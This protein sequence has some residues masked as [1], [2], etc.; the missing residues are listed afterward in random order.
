MSI[1][2]SHMIKTEYILTYTKYNC[3]WYSVTKSCLTLCDHVDCVAPGSSVNGILQARVLACVLISCSRGFSQTRNQTVS[4]ARAG[5]FFTT[6]LPWRPTDYNIHAHKQQENEMVSSAKKNAVERV[7]KLQA[8]AWDC[9]KER[10][11]FLVL[12]FSPV[13]RFWLG[14]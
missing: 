8:G 3:C 5:G 11:L 13:L 9:A 14:F 7:P 6:D 2:N 1:D 4:P 12:S 10:V